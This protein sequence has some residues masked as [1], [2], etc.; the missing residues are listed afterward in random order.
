M[1]GDP[2]VQ[3]KVLF[4]EWANPSQTEMRKRCQKEGGLKKDARLAGWRRSNQ[5]SLGRVVRLLEFRTSNY[6]SSRH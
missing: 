3:E 5:E 1:T 6:Y 2:S 4:V